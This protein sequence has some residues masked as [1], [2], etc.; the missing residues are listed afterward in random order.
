MQSLGWPNQRPRK[1][2]HLESSARLSYSIIA[3]RATTLQESM[4][5]AVSRASERDTRRR[6]ERNYCNKKHNRRAPN[7]RPLRSAPSFR[8]LIYAGVKLC[9]SLSPLPPFSSS[10]SRLANESP[11]LFA[12]RFFWNA[13]R[14]GETRNVG[15]GREDGRKGELR[16]T[17]TNKALGCISSPP[18]KQRRAAD[19]RRVR[20]RSLS[21]SSFLFVFLF[22]D[23]ADKRRVG[24]LATVTAT[25]V[26]G[27]HS[28]SRSGCAADLFPYFS[29]YLLPIRPSFLFWQKEQQRRQQRP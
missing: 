27:R 10:L 4:I 26:D 5:F 9:Q 24:W 7:F 22:G 11:S 25:A 20:R 2:S 6:C 15:H 13:R 23:S 21:L 17:T 28:H 14:A 12:P 19:T 18:E 16:T 8:S 29:S 1:L 3:T